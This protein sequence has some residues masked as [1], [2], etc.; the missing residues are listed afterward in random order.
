MAA[1]TTACNA[2]PPQ[3]PS[4]TERFP[5]TLH[6][7]PNPPTTGTHHSKFALLFAE[8]RRGVRVMITT[9]NFIQI[10]WENKTEARFFF[11][12][13]RCGGDGHTCIHLLH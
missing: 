10:D 6:T 8:G 4:L 1:L 11:F 12:V 3:P 5:L 9:A 7:T 2:M 13:C